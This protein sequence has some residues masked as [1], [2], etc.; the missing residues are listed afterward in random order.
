MNSRLLAADAAIGARP[1]AVLTLRHFRVAFRQKTVLSSVD[2]EL[3]PGVP[4]VLVGP[5]AAGKSTLLRTLAGLN[6][7]GEAIITGDATLAG[8]PLSSQNHIA[9]VGQRAA[10]WIGSLADG[11]APMDAVVDPSSEAAGL[12]LPGGRAQR[13]ERAVAMLERL[14]LAHLKGRLARPM[15]ELSTVDARLALLA[16]FAAEAPTM[17]ALDEPTTGMTHA[18]LF[19]YCTAVREVATLTPVFVATHNQLVAREIGGNTALLAG[20]RIVEVRDTSSF[21]LT[22]QTA[23]AKQFVRTGSCPS[24]SPDTDPEDVD[25]DLRGRFPELFEGPP[26]STGDDFLR[27]CE[28]FLP[29]SGDAIAPPASLRTPTVPYL[30]NKHEAKTLELPGNSADATS[31]RDVSEEPT[32]AV[33]LR[34]PPAPQVDVETG[35]GGDREA[36]TEPVKLERRRERAGPAFAGRLLPAWVYQAPARTNPP[37]ARLGGCRRPG[38]LAELEDDLEDLRE[39]GVNVLVSL[40]AEHRISS[41]EVAA[42]GMVHHQVPFADMRA[43]AAHDMIDLC[44]EIDSLFAK[45]LSVCVHCKAGLGRTGTVLA[46]YLIWKGL[47]VHEAIA[48][49]R[50]REPKF[51]ST[52]AQEQFLVALSAAIHVQRLG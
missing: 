6:F 32:T 14:G 17:L 20:G 21:F 30:G 23:S 27:P 7:H 35:T 46:G 29:P 49:I 43:P 16:R 9:L 4:Q 41:E 2:L 50:K 11:L 37:P 38:L 51:V 24:P 47:D 15:L 39:A 10:S 45:N 3:F 13:L 34:S 36:A 40:E 5:V 26:A 48:T 33:H 25:P 42:H 12:A 52:D 19:H 8:A 28:S 1:L 18:E 22:P 44:I 31:P